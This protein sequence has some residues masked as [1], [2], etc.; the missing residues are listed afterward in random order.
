MTSIIL[1]ALYTLV[2]L[3]KSGPISPFLMTGPLL[4]CI[5]KGLVINYGEGGAT[6]WENRGS[7]TFCTPL[8]D[9]VK[10]FAPPFYRV[11][12]FYGTPF[13]MAKTSTTSNFVG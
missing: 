13:N 1:I 7:K 2:F 3:F 11:E 12:T 8:Q 10:P 5:G 4:E 9:R 6:K